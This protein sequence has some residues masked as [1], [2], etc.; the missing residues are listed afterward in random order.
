[1]LTLFCRADVCNTAVK[2]LVGKVKPDNQKRVGGWAVMAHLLN[3]STRVTRSLVQAA[4]GFCDAKVCKGYTNYE[5]CYIFIYR[6]ALKI[7]DALIYSK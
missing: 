5:F 2:K 6:N 3:C 1:M 4:N 7:T